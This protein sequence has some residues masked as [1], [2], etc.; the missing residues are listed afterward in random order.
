[1]LYSIGIENL[2]HVE[3]LRNQQSNDIS[4]EELDEIYTKNEQKPRK[5]MFCY[6]VKVGMKDMVL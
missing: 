4:P 1:L 3:M 5:R 6:I 2:A